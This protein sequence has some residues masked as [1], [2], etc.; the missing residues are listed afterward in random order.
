MRDDPEV[1]GDGL[2][3][4]LPFP[5]KRCVEKVHDRLGELPEIRTA[6]VVR[7]IPVHDASQSL[8]RVQMGGVGR[9]E[10]QPDAAVRPC[11]ERFGFLA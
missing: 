9:Q 4:P 11:R 5:G 10:V 7:H 3:G 6:P 1:V 2:C 8:N